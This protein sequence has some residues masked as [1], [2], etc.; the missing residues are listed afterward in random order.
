MCILELWPTAHW[1]SDLM[2]INVYMFSH[3]YCSG[4]GG[5]DSTNIGVPQKSHNGQITCH[6]YHLTCFVVLTDVSGESGGQVM[7]IHRHS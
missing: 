4:D 3:Y 5:W 7:Y 6:S 1:V 2:C